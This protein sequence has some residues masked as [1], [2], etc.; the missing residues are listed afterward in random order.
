MTT[1]PVM[2]VDDAV[3]AELEAIMNEPGSVLTGVSSRANRAR[4]PAPFP[5]HRWAEHMPAVVVLPRTAEQVSE[6]VKLANR[7]RIPVVP[8]AGG[9]GLNDGAVPLRGGILVDV[10]RMNQ[11]HE[12]DL[13]D[14]TVTVGP[15]I[16]MLKLNEEL[17]Q[18]GVFFPDTPASYPCSLVGGRI[19]CSGFSLLGTRFGHTRD[20]VMSFEMVLPTGEIIRVGDGGGKKIRK[21]S[22][23]YHLKHLFMGHQGTLGIVTEAT[24]ELVPRPEA[25][26]AAFFAFDD[27][28]NAHRTVHGIVTSG[29]AT[30]AGTVLFDEKKVEYLRRDDEAFIPM[31]P[32][33]NS[34][35][36]TAC[37]ARRRKYAR[38]RR[39]SWTSAAR[40]WPVHG[41]RDGRGR[42]GVTARPLREPSPWAP[43]G[44]QRGPDVVALRGRVRELER[45]PKV[46]DEWRAIAQVHRQVRHLRQLGDVLLYQRVLQAVGRLPHRDRHRD[47]GGEARRRDVGR[48]ARFQDRDRQ[49]D[50]EVRRFDQQLPRDHPIR[51]RRARPRRDGWRLGRHAQD[52]AGPRP[53]QHYE[54]WQADAGPGIRELR[55]N[56]CD[57]SSTSSSTSARSNPGLGRRDHRLEHVYEVDPDLMGTHF[58]QQNMPCGTRSASW[59][60]AMS[61]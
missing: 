34:I 59:R 7:A 50:A 17:K 37:T 45:D 27:F 40:R 6:I 38:R 35:V 1:A 30:L 46:R 58:R 11:I 53:E 21:S 57:G 49:G 13:A 32:W 23:G 10:K 31:P 36:A 42:L 9:T 39:S 44:R 43:P 61:T 5:V 48:L 4:V 22:T 24:L 16:S 14:R 3:V 8:R 41:R 12:I 47:L 15:G 55:A 54:P 51:R 28:L 52:Q 18:Y 2:T 19:A 56:R 33:V 25:E 26:F 60:A 20:L 29:I